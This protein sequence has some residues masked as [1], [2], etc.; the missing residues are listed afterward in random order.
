MGWQYTIPPGEEINNGLRQFD[1]V[2][3]LTF[4]LA[5]VS[6]PNSKTFPAQLSLA[7]SSFYF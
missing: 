4:F 5:M 6:Y 1:L 3:I 2:W 7:N